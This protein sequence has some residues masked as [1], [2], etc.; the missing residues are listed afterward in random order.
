[1]PMPILTHFNIKLRA[2]KVHRVIIR[3][4]VSFF[5]EGGHTGMSTRTSV[6]VFNGNVVS[7][8]HASADSVDKAR[9]VLSNLPT[10]FS[11][12]N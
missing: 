2:Q 6:S 7:C 8:A 11:F 4:N 5:G 10:I 9:Y 1:M 3:V 12:N